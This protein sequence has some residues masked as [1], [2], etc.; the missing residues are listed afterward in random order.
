M[1]SRYDDA[2]SCKADDWGL[3]I[4]LWFGRH[5]GRAFTAFGMT[6]LPDAPR[7]ELHKGRGPQERTSHAGRTQIVVTI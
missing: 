2:V 6:P 1:T 4:G 7:S 3:L 5:V